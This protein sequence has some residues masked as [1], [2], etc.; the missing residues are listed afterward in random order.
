MAYQ[1]QT[2]KGLVNRGNWYRL[3]EC[4]RRAEG[5]D[6]IT[7]GF[8]G[9]S[10]TQGAVAETH[11][12]C[13]AYLVF[14]WWVKKFPK[15]A[16]TYVNAGIGG[17]TSQFGVARAQSDLLSSR[18]DVVF[19]EFSVND[20][21]NDFFKETYEGLVRKIYDA[22]LKPAVTLIHNVM[23]DHG[24]T[25]Q[26][27]HQAVGM[28]YDLPCVAMKPVIYAEVEAGRIPNRDI[29]P[30]DLHPN[31]AGHAL[32]AS[33]IIAYLEKVYAELSKEEAQPNAMP[34]PLTDNHYQNSIRLQNNNASPD[35]DG[36]TADLTPQRLVLEGFRNGWT[37]GKQGAK[38]TFE[39]E[40]SEI[41]V[42]YRKTITQPAPIAKAVVDGDEA[43]AVILDANFDETWGDCLFMQNLLVHGENRKHTVEIT[44]TQT[45]ADD[46]SLFYLISLIVSH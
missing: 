5:G 45:H 10:I 16:F 24:K 33:V 27:I 42:Q 39:A 37:A 28:H 46:A 43:N 8:L 26:E 30:D 36:W 21:N 40:G 15:T 2:E 17:T 19:V 11:T 18:P 13:Y 12:T 23:Y 1:I 22:P 38:I 7:I 31:T 25:A 4:M 44:L 34:A 29:T 41:A 20:E 6:R 3:K 32:V 14:D 9:G 35:L